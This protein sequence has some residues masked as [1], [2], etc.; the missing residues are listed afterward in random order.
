MFHDDFV[1]MFVFFEMFYGALIERV[2]ER[3]L[4]SE[5]VFFWTITIIFF[6]LA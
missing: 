1:C 5:G 3:D 6:V 4:N 2:K